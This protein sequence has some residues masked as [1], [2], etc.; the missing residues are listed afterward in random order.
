MFN[1]LAVIG[2]ATVIAP[3][4]NIPLEVLHRDWLVMLALTMVFLVMAYGF[5]KK[6]GRITR[7]EGMFLIVCYVAY[8]TYLGMT[9][10]GSL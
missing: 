5:K 7:I 1:I 3:M 10:T 4:N 9:L 2:L 6:E 8:N